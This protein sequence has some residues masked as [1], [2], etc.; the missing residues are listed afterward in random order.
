MRLLNA[1]ITVQLLI[2]TFD[3][4]GIVHYGIAGSTNDSLLIGDVSVPK[5][6]A[7]TSSWK[8]KVLAEINFT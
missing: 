8:W 4:V 1:G 6:V 2:D 5:Y 3:V 7:Q